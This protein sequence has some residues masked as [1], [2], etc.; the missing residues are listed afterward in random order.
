MSYQVHNFQSGDVLYASQLNDM[1]VQI[2]ENSDSE[3]FVGSYNGTFTASNQSVDTGILMKANKTYHIK[4]DTPRDGTFGVYRSGYSNSTKYVRPYFDEVYFPNIGTDG[5]LYLYSFD[6]SANETVSL[7]VY[8]VNSVQAKSQDVPRVYRVN[9]SST[10]LGD[11]TSV[12]ECFLSLKDDPNPKIIEIWEGDYD[13]YQ[14]YVDANIPVYTGNDPSMEF[15]DY[16]VYVPENAHV[17]GKGLV[18]LKWM[19]DPSIDNI[20]PNQCKCVSPINVRK[21]MTLENIELHCKNGRYCIHNDTLGYAAYAGAVWKFINV[22]CYKYI[23]DTNNGVS[24][25][26]SSALG[27]GM[28]R[29]MFHYYENCEFHNENTNSYGWAFYGH[30]NSVYRIG[31]EQNTI[32]ESQSGEIVLNNCVLDTA[33]DVCIKLGNSS[34]IRRKIKTKFNNCY[35]SGSIR[36]VDEDGGGGTKP[37]NFDLTL[38]DCNDVDIFIAESLNPYQPKFYKIDKA[39]LIVRFTEIIGGAIIP[40]VSASEIVKA[41]NLGKDV[42]GLLIE[43]NERLRLVNYSISNTQQLLRCTFQSQYVNFNV[44]PQSM[45]SITL[46]YNNGLWTKYYNTYALSEI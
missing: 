44:T 15:S 25:G 24:Y 3:G 18:R 40:S 34:T 1:D 11:F 38:C 4:F 45:Y 42:I 46:D 37:N 21:S 33:E 16:C 27:F 36:V 7:K 14:E 9:K 39:P 22:K 6:S 12:T 26:F 8:E 20:T 2:K 23:N 41:I 30:T 19:P 35:I 32:P 29:S 31:S 13:I 10:Y 43:F 28:G 17:I 5:N